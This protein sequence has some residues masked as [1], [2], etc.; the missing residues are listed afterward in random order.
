MEHVRKYSIKKGRI[1]VK[2]NQCEGFVMV[3]VLVTVM[4]VMT[5]TSLLFSSAARR[6]RA[7]LNF[8][9][10]TEARLAAETVVQILSEN[11]LQDEPT[12][13]LEK[14][15]GP[16][17]LTETEAV[18]WA[19]SGDGE[20]KKIETIVS[21]YWKEDGS[22]LVLHADCIVNGQK[23]GA[24]RLIPVEHILVYTPSSA[25]RIRGNKL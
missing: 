18:V 14:L 10:G 22:G 24:S 1:T 9:A 8:A 7:A 21:S 4:F 5:F 15:Q 20:E 19:E 13:I 17:G 25:E 11:M 12:G 16:D 23:E 6:Y 3:E 2:K